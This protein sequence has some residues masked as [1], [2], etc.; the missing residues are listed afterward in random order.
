M[1][2]AAATAGA[3]AQAAED[4][5]RNDGCGKV[6]K[7][8]SKLA[9]REEELQRKKERDALEE[10][11]TATATKKKNEPPKKKTQFEL[12]ALL[13]P[14]KKKEKPKKEEPLERN[15]NHVRMEE[16][17]AAGNAM[18]ASGVDGATALLQQLK[19]GATLLTTR[20][21]IPSAVARLR[22][23]HTRNERSRGCEKR[24]QA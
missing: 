20:M 16:A 10:A 1:G 12:M 5:S 24:I 8:A 13:N 4:A 7:N 17:A 11:E 9:K 6:D 22:S 18:A 2:K 23:R 3:A 15:I 19:T 14:P 21:Q